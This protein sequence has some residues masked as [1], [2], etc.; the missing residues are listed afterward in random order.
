MAKHHPT[1][2]RVHRATNDEDVFVSSVLETSV[3]ARSHSRLLIIGVTL[4]IVAVAVTVYVRSM[5]SSLVERGAAELSQVRAT[6]AS[7]NL[8]L[9]KQDLER[10]VNRFGK[11][12]SGVEARM[13]LAQVQLQT[14]EPAKAVATLKSV[15]S[16][17]DSP[18]GYSAALMLG[19]AH[20]ANKQLDEA[21]RVYLRAAD[22]ARFDFQKREALDRAARVRVERGNLAG[23]AELYERVVATFA[24]D[25]IDLVQEKNA[26]L[27]RLAEL[28]AQLPAT[29]G[30]S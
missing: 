13:M 27:M 30:R 1:A 29:A 12:P 7:G 28:K 8:P 5:R 19:G 17:A 14:N 15:D 24:E 6:V 26:Y 21:E 4:A 10:F 2:R 18:I 3:W 9:A 25:E 20:E 23:A 22:D 11:T 16:D